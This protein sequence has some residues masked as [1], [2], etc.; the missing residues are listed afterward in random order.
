M[1]PYSEKS[2]K[3]RE[4]NKVHIEEWKG[5][6]KELL[7]RRTQEWWN[8]ERFEMEIGSSLSDAKLRDAWF[9]ITYYV[10]KSTPYSKSQLVK[11]FK[12]AINEIIDFG[13]LEPSRKRKL[14][15]SVATIRRKTHGR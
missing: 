13:I 2:K 15:K 8:T 4:E 3:W 7:N 12:N 11:F 6:F 5:K 10:A 9:F 14:L 1:A